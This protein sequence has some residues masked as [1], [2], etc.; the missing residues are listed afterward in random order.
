MLE[1]LVIRLLLAVNI[2]LAGLVGWQLRRLVT[3]FESLHDRVIGEHMTRTDVLALHNANRLDIHDLRCDIQRVSTQIAVLEQIKQM[4]HAGLIIK[5][6][7]LK[8][9]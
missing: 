2:G 3:R 9:S 8:P 7:S 4:E 5:P 6:V 1:D